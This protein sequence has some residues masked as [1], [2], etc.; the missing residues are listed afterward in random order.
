MSCSASSLA[1]SESLTGTATS[2][3]RWLLV[4]VRGTWGRDVVADSGLSDEI[5]ATLAGFPGKVLF[6]R[7]PD[8]KDGV[9]VCAVT[10]SESGGSA[11]SQ[12]LDRLADL[13]DADFEAGEPVAGPIVLVCAHGRRDACCATLGVPLY[14]AL[15]GLLP[16]RRLWQSSHLGGH[17]FAPNL[18][19]LPH[20]VQ[21]GR[22][23]IDRAAEVTELLAAGRIPLDLY[24]GR[25]IYEPPVQAAELAVRHETRCDAIADL[26][27]LAHVGGTVSFATPGGE[28]EVRV[29]EL[30]GPLVPVS[31]GADPEP[32]RA[33]VTSLA[34]ALQ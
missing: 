26:R 13:P 15:D 11:R 20:G 8:S 7:R 2:G 16:P 32:T 25:T 27:L 23:P 14:A 24:R 22:I 34:G 31:C 19:V 6:V 30:P 12:R 4:E 9:F 3:T 33:W 21:L 29:E 1:A 28:L 18:L 10:A 5:R 17:R